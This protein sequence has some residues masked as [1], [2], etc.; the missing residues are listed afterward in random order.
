MHSSSVIVLCTIEKEKVIVPCFFENEN[1]NGE[2][3][4]NMEI[5]YAFHRFVS[6]RKDY[7]YHQDR[8]PPHDSNRARNNLIRKRPGN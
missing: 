6:L 2:N 3:Y 5:N 4:R 1:V 7:I 8:V